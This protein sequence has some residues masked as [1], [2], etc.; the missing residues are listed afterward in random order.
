MNVKRRHVLQALGGLLTAPLW[1][2]VAHAQSA[3]TAFTQPN[4]LFIT[5]DDLG[6]PAIGSYGNPFVPTPNIDRLAQ[7]G[8]RFTDA[9]VTPQCTPTRASLLTGQHT[10]RNGM[11]HVIG[12]YYYPYAKV[13][14]P[15]YVEHLPREAFTMGEVLQTVGYQTAYLGK[16]HLTNTEDGY[17]TYLTETGKQY[18]GFDY[19]NPVTEPSQYQRYGDKG[20]NFLT[21]EAI[22]FMERHQDNP[23]FIYLSHHSIHGPILAPEEIVAQYRAQGYPE[24]GLHNAVYLAAI[25]HLDQA[26]GR[27]LNRLDALQLTQN[28]LVI[29]MSD[30]GGVDAYFDNAPLRYGKGSVYEGGIRVPFLIRWP[31][32]IPPNSI[33]TTPIYATDLY[34]TFAEVTGAVVPENHILDGKSIVPLF[35]QQTGWDRDTLYWFMPLYDVRWGATPAA[36]IREGNYKLIHFFGDYIDL[37]QG[38]QYITESRVELYDLGADMSES[39]DLSDFA[40]RKTQDLLNKLHTWMSSLGHSIPEDNPNFDINRWNEEVRPERK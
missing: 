37:D 28:T 30:N 36:I 2:H 3:A 20:V 18:Y 25:Q 7:E 9:Y 16:W 32:A 5:I 27:L 22:Q 29:F 33:S 1:Q 21:D 39:F 23:F 8:M 4:I 35:Q 34:P 19:V 10:A 14:E 12:P 13:Q 26:I 40:P 31:R 38:G 15:R 17:Y 24:A 6:W 11:W